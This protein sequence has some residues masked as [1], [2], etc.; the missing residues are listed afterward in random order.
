MIKRINFEMEKKKYFVHLFM[1]SVEIEHIWCTKMRRRNFNFIRTRHFNR[2]WW[3]KNN[4]CFHSTGGAQTR[5]VIACSLACLILI[6]LLD[7]SPVYSL[8]LSR[9][10]FTKRRHRVC[11]VHTAHSDRIGM[12]DYFFLHWLIYITALIHVM[13][14][15]NLHDF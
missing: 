14:P 12:F 9:Q 7:L 2:I 6:E 5:D 1:V 4:H 15:K 3:Q 8:P 11:T 13:K 10:L